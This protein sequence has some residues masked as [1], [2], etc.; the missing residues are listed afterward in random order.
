[1][2]APFGFANSISV[3]GEF[4][5]SNRTSH[6]PVKRHFISDHRGATVSLTTEA[7]LFK[8]V[9]V[10]AAQQDNE[11]NMDNDYNMSEKTN[12][13]RAKEEATEVKPCQIQLDHLK[14]L[15]GEADKVQFV[16]HISSHLFHMCSPLSAFSA[17]FGQIFPL[18]HI[19]LRGHD[20]LDFHLG[21]PFI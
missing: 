9:H 2:K 5:L 16:Q 11:T 3:C 12:R 7:F 10:L 14:S 1:M 6:F 20:D 13:G 18:S 4:T 8:R 15:A 17:T 19:T 21:A